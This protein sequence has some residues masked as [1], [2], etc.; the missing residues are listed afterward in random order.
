MEVNQEIK[1]LHNFE[2]DSKWFHEHTNELRNKGF[3]SKFVA[4]KNEKAIASDNNLNVV[5]KT[6]TKQGE[7]PSFLF[8]EFVYPK[9]TILIL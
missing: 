8:I 3:T 5:I 9:G 7:N 1:L 4:I 2:R 6:I